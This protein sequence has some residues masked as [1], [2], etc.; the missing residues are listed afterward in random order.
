MA[1]QQ[2][3]LHTPLLA[4]AHLR[5]QHHAHVLPAVQ[6]RHHFE[7]EVG[8]GD[9]QGEGG[10]RGGTHWDQGVNSVTERGT[11]RPRRPQASAAFSLSQQAAQCTPL[12]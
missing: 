7:E 9:L 10:K 6:K 12:R 5:R 3:L 2:Q 4:P 8:V 1:L 11:E